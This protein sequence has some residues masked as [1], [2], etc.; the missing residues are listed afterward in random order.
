MIVLD[1][2][3]LSE[4]L[5]AV[6]AEAVMAWLASQSSAAL[7]TTTV[8][9]GELFYGI[10]LMADGQRKNDLWLA[11]QAIFDQDLV[12][13]VLSFDA[14]AAD[15]FASI[16]ASRKRAGHPISQFDAMI[17]AFT[18]SRGAKLATRNTKDFADC[19]VELINPWG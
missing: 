11:A 4:A 12:G 18:L 17:A 15:A 13:Q 16:C 14:S 9:R 19:G 10:Q 7:F 8:T 2:H 1:T 5:R 3:V 6:P